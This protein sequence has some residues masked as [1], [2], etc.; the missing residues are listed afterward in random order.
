MEPTLLLLNIRKLEYLKDSFDFM[1]RID[2]QCT[3]NTIL[4]TCD[5]KSL[6]TNIK[7]DVFYKA[8][9]Y[10]I[11]KFHDGIPLLSRF[12]KAFI[13]EGLNIIFKFNYFYINKN[14]FHQIKGTA[15]GT[16]FAIV[17]SNL[18][19]A[20][21]EVKM[22]ALLPQIYPRDFVDYFVR[23]YFRFLD[24]IFHTWLINFDIEPFSKLINE[25][26]PDLKF[27]FEKLTTDINFLDKNIKIVDNQL[28]FDIYHSPTSSFSY[29]K[30]KSC[31]PSHTKNN[32]LLSLARSI[33]RIVTDNRDYRLE[34][35]RQ[36]LLKRKHPEKI[37]NYSF[38]KSFRPKS[39][40]EENKEIVTFTRKY[41]PN[42][43]CDYN[44]FN[45]CLS[46]INNREL[47]ETFNN[48]KVLLTTRQPNNLKKM[49]VTAKFDLH[50]ELPNRKPNGLF[51]CT[52]C[53]YH[54]NANHLPLNLQMRNLLLGTTIKFFIAIVKIFYIS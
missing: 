38:T 17:G 34:Q 2:T 11:D 20:Y 9:E 49:L 25:R 39:N 12:T 4:S 15:M 32:I 26:D 37:I 35:L 14:F 24:D 31:H 28:H 54:K 27:V 18:T 43:N 21:F 46:N 23:N 13:L 52:D 7:H 51:S 19:V 40:K 53:I 45:N 48:K 41:N 22:F 3:V 30:Y 50:S 29:L 8:I 47:R 5:I 33:I 44:R 1:D 6:Y 36:N 16:I 10:W 42:H